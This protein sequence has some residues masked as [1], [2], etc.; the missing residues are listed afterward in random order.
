MVEEGGDDTYR[1]GG[2]YGFYET[3]DSS[4][5]QGAASG[6][7]PWP[8][9]GKTTLYGGVGFLSEG[10]GNDTYHCYNIGQGASY[11]LS[12]GMLVDREGDDTYTGR[13]YTRG[14]GVHLSAG[15]CLDLAGND[16]HRGEYGQNGMSLDRSAGV[17]VDLAGDDVYCARGS[18]GFSTKPRGFSLFLDARGDDQYGGKGRFFGFANVPYGEDAESTSFF[19]DFG[20]RDVYPKGRFGN[21]AAWTE[22]FYGQGVDVELPDPAQ[23]DG[24]VWRPGPPPKSEGLPERLWPLDSPWTLARFHAWRRAFGQSAKLLDVLDPLAAKGRLAT[25]REFIDVVQS[26]VQTKRFPQSDAW[27]LAAFLDSEDRDLAILGLWAMGRLK[28]DEADLTHRAARLLA[29]SHSSDLRSMACMALGFSTRPEAG[30]ALRRALSDPSWPVRRQA[31]LACKERR[32]PMARDELVRLITDDAV[33]EVRARAAEALGSLT[34]PRNPAIL[35]KALADPAEIVR[36]YAARALLLQHSRIY[37]L[38]RLFPLL[39]W[40]SPVLRNRLVLGFLRS[41]T[42][43][44]LP[45]RPAPWQ[46]WWKKAQSAFRLPLHYRMHRFFELAARR[47]RDGDEDGAIYLYRNIRKLFPRH[48]GACRELGRRLNS[49]AWKAALSG[50]DLAK[51]LALARESVE[52]HANVDNTDTLSVLLYLTGDR[53][54][55]LSVLLKGIETFEK[56]EKDGTLHERLRQVR[57]GKLK[58]N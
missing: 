26:W 42:G 13:N 14:V 4:C 39:S 2:K 16:L 18:F 43:Q 8:P 23:E 55:A 33:P 29:S 41:F 46:A 58:L 47:L 10:S 19:F 27:K 17:F 6:L 31:V 45:A 15:V 36:F 30:S 38:P 1:A 3:W 53:E 25:R 9:F 11:L 34:D 35:E 44:D 20:G 52:A 21:N 40:Q 50:K 5:A 57:A 51:G 28:T 7:R 56:G 54:E 48:A 32:D 22:R 49:R 12:L 24:P 37:A